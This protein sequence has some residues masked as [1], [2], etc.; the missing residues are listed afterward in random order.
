MTLLTVG[1]N[2][3]TAPL[4]IRERAAF[5]A[6]QIDSAVEAF[7]CLPA[8]TE[9]A[10][11]STCN[12]TELY[13][14]T[15]AGDDAGLCAWLCRQRGLDPKTMADCF[16][17]YRGRESVRQ[18]LRVAAGLD[19]MVLGEPQILGQMKAAYRSARAARGAGPLL[20]RLFEHSFAVAKQVR[21]QTDIGANP[22]SVAYAGV[23][24]A[25]QIFT[26]LSTTRA[27]LVGAG[28]T[29]ELTARYLAAIGVSRMVFA[30]RS[31]E[32][33]RKLAE[34]YHGQAIALADI[35]AYLPQADILIT[36]TAAPGYLIHFS[37]LR[38]A[39]KQ[40][41]HKP[42]FALDLAV[43]RDI[44]P[45]AGELEDVYLYSVDDLQ[46]VIEENKRSRQIAA[47]RADAMLDARIDEYL[48]WV[49]SRRAVATIRA[50]RDD[51]EASRQQ[52]LARARR[53]LAR[54]RAPDDVL[55][56]LSHTLT[57][58]L[59]HAPSAGLRQA[60]GQRQQRLLASARELFDIQRDAGVE[61]DTNDAPPDATHNDAHHDS[62]HDTKS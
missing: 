36:S 24:L 11:L 27:M 45:A 50:L 39:V 40:R 19:S 3:N 54:G 17:V 56:L 60:R 43:P 22:V 44:D 4:A 2:H 13:A 23:S 20:T 61:H 8:I 31:V 41:R 5:P 16:Y 9:G 32:R 1:L 53:Q 47:E 29:I 25:R 51:A 14:V 58:K 30:N 57:N 37:D 49:D 15:E 26:D 7:L 33:T 55:E 59:I 35:P 62:H 18:S 38:A 6:D 12:R 42:I 34:R 28:Q 52:V 48:D 46:G 21:S 10:I